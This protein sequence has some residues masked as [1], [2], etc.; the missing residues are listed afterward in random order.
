MMGHSEAPYS[1]NYWGYNAESQFL[2]NRG[3]AVL[4]VNYR[5]ST[6]YGKDFHSAGFKEVGGKI[7]QDITD[8]VNWL[9]EQQNRK[10]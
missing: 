8:G 2:A 9:I 10:P 7:Q 6:G 5:G 1:R 3:Y 4:Q